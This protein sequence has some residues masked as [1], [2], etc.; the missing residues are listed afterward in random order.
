MSLTRAGA[1]PTMRAMIAVSSTCRMIAALL[2]LLPSPPTGGGPEYTH[3]LVEVRTLVID[4]LGTRTVD[5]DRARVPFGSKGLLIRQVPYGGPPLSFRLSVLAGPPQEAGIPLTLAAEIGGGG[6]G[7]AAAGE[8][9]AARGG[10]RG[11]SRRLLSLRDRSRRKTDRRVVLSIS[12]RAITGQEA[13]MP[14]MPE[15]A[16]RPVH[17]FI[18]VV[19]QVGST[20]DPPDTHALTSLVGRPVTYSSGITIHR[21]PGPG[22]PGADRTASKTAGLTVTLTAEQVLDRL[23]T[24]KVR[25]SGADYVDAERTR[26]EP[27]EVTRMQTVTSGSPFEIVARIPPQG[28]EDGGET[29]QEEGLRPVT[30]LVQ[31]TASLD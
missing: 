17:F 22:G 19:R 2:T 1:T 6:R 10:H 21:G 3:A 18:A 26:L 8:R 9:L 15:Q 28:D 14:S 23:I 13:L 20:T 27:I 4:G 24:V 16:A 25:L 7:R 12:A 30:Y 29:P 31:V 11:L 5:T